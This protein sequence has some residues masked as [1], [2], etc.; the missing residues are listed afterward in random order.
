MHD[1]TL[2]QCYQILELW[3]GHYTDREIR[4]KLNLTPQQMYNCIAHIQND[5]HFFTD[6]MALFKR[7]LVDIKNW[8]QR[9]EAELELT[10]DRR[11]RISLLKELGTVAD[12]VATIAL[13]YG[14]EHLSRVIAESDKKEEA[15]Y[16]AMSVAD[17]V[18][19]TKKDA[20]KWILPN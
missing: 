12:K 5:E 4:E 20:Q 3:K 1:K 11:L 14:V 7:G 17:L 13:K 19:L 18:A 15:E 2:H 16:D 10:T 8:A 9:I 6:A